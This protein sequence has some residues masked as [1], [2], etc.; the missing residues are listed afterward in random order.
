MGPDH[1]P[2]VDVEQGTARAWLA[3]TIAHAQLIA[4]VL[5]AV[6]AP[7]DGAVVPGW[8]QRQFTQNMRD[9]NNIHHRVW[10]WQVK[11]LSSN[12][13]SARPPGFRPSRAIIEQGLDERTLA[14]LG[15]TIV[16]ADP[17]LENQIDASIPALINGRVECGK[18]STIVGRR[19]NEKNEVLRAWNQTCR[20]KDNTYRYMHDTYRYMH[21][22]A[23]TYARNQLPCVAWAA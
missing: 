4:R 10:G 17:H 18:R 19:R 2:R 11:A 14:L 13:G 1:G 22:H 15:A 3:L 7:G 12:L 20:Y 5:A 9:G 8:N 23:H 21:I 16:G 6:H